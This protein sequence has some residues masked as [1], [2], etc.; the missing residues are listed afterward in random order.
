MTTTAQNASLINGVDPT[1]V[2]ELVAAIDE[3]PANAH[4]S[5]S[6]TNRWENGNVQQ[7]TVNPGTI[8]SQRVDRPFT[9]KVDEPLELGGTNTAPNPQDY[10]LAGMN[11]CILT[12][13]VDN[14]AL[15]GI[16]LESIE[17]ESHGDIDL[18]GLFG[19]EGVAPS[20]DDITY[21]IRV[22]ADATPE[23]LQE[24]HDAVKRTSPNYHNIARAIALKA[25]LVVE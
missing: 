9:F 4:T 24:I 13:Y 15:L 19:W 6:V 7:I 10:L 14:A 16:R 11:A 18:R 3:N 2:R 5:W 20:Y 12:T 23:Q 1:A 25:K 17:I 8:G 21:T 22:K